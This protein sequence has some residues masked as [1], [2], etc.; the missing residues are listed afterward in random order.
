M[1]AGAIEALRVPTN[2]LDVL[3]QQV[4]A[5]AP[6][7]T[8]W[9]VD[10]AAS[11][12][13]AAS[14]PFATL[15]R[16]GA[17][18][19]TLD[20]LAG[21]YPSDEFAELRPADRLGP[22]HRRRSPAAPAPSGSP[23][24]AAAPSPT[25]AC[26]A[27]SSSGEE[28]GRRVGE[29]D[30]EMVYESRVG[31]VFALGATHAGG[32]RTSP[33]TG[34][35]SPPRPGSPGRLP[36]WK[37]DSLGRPAELG[38][39]DRRVHPRARR[40]ARREADARE[41]ARPPGST[42]GPPTTSSPTSREQREATGTCPDD[43][44]IVVERFRDELGDW[45]LVVHSP[46][47]A[48]VHAPWAL[49][50]QRPAA[51][52]LR[53][54]RARRCPPTTASCCAIP[55]D[56]RTDAAAAAERDR[57]RARRDRGR[58]SPTRSAARPC[59]P[60]RFRECAARA[61]LLPRRDP[62]RRAAAV[63][64]A[65][66][67]A[68]S[69][70][71]SPPKYPLVPDRARGRPRV[72]PGR[73]RPARAGRP[74]ARH[75][76]PR[77]HGRRRR[78][79]RSPSPFATSPAVRLR[80][81]SSSTRATPRS[82]SG[83]PPRSPSTR[84][85]SPS[86]SARAE[87]REL[88]DPDV[89]RRASR[90][91]CSGSP[92]RPPRARRRGRRRPAAAARPARRPAEVR[93]ARRRRRRRRG[94]AGRRSRDGPPGRPGADRRRGALGRRRGRRA[95]CATRSACPLPPGTPRRLHS[96]RSTTRSAT[97]SRRYARTHGPFTTGRGGRPASAS[98]SRSP[99]TTLA[100]L[101]AQGRVLEG[102]FRPAGG[103]SGVVRRRGAAH[104]PAPLARRACA[105]RSSR[106]SRP[107]LARFLPAWQRRPGGRRLRGVD[108]VLAVVEQ[109]RRLRRSRRRALESLVL[110]ARVARLRPRD[111]RRAD[112]RR[113]GALGRARRRCPAPTAGSR[114][115]SPT[116]PTSP[117]P[118]RTPIE[119]HRVA[120]TRV[121]DALAGGGA[122]FFRPLSDP[123]GSDRRR[124]PWPQAAVGPRLVRPGHQ[125]HPRPGA[126]PA[127]RRPD[128]APAPRPGPAVPLRDPARAARRARLGAVP[129]RP[130]VALRPARVAAA[131]RCCRPAEADPTRR[132]HATAELPA[133]PARRGHPRRGRR[134]RG[135]RRLRR[136]LQGARRRSRR[137]GGAAAATSSRVSA[138]P[139]SARPA[140][141]TGCA[142]A[143]GGDRAGDPDRHG[144][145]GGHRPGQPLRRRAALARACRRPPPP[146]AEGTR[147]A[148]ARAQ[149]GR[150][151][152]P[153]RRRA[154]A[155][156]RARRQD[157]A[158]L[159]RGP[160][161]ARPGRHGPGRRRA[162]RR[163]SAGSP[164]R[165]PTAGGCSAA[166]TPSSAHSRPPAST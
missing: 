4:V 16:V 88:L 102:E 134:E 125:R 117:C 104:A 96:S 158:H 92:E 144:G 27:S 150:R 163:T 149:G 33:T 140:P 13:C 3:A 86:C 64:A 127:R 65:A 137:A 98:A 110:P 31:D 75:R 46:F 153:R 42:T 5:D 87:L 152:R 112:R 49:A 85:C 166:S 109:L 94:L 70:S 126:G 131:G 78:D 52:A 1:R 114:C 58:S 77:G 91:S 147:R 24:P 10:D 105:R 130:A 129:A 118:T 69:C 47:G 39:G 36:F 148:P 84:R 136:G 50:D 68:P 29:L 103:G 44:T 15:P 26:S 23:S 48:P 121:L 160:R 116:P 80:R 141:S 139:S 161:P 72:P 74:D 107:T 12:W 79:H 89:A 60:S 164:S 20:L 41:R 165:R 32:S 138:P 95:G 162:P 111:A 100:R 22:R 106:S 81:R 154:R 7:S 21:R 19:P 82:P 67:V 142:P 71:R 119:A 34:C 132:A 45:R 115:T 63:A 66:A 11:R 99:T 40:A 35:S 135:A 43:R 2:P 97:W 90:P 143:A 38:R 61:L 151:G 145:A 124:R 93:R 8:T 108:G 101:A 30:E 76:R 6:R 156:R 73:L 159:H 53:R 123:V 128:R 59:S 157:P 9:D 18:T 14:A 28:T 56:R 62:G 83:G 155:L 25:A 55:D 133:R 120:A 37:G 57:L 113:R 122:Y 17:S 51:R 54:R 146:R